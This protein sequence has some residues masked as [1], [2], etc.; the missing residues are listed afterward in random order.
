MRDFENMDSAIAER[1]SAEG[2]LIKEDGHY[3][4]S[5]DYKSSFSEKLKGFNLKHLQ[6][7]A[8]C[9]KANTFINRTTLS[10]I[11]GEEL[12]DRQVRF[13]ITKMEKAG[14]IERKGG[15]KYVQYFQTA[16]FPK[17]N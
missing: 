5:D 2:L 1:L 8:E 16:D 15:G 6:M 10:E 13:L 4:L 12:S 17:F 3:R 14:F 7:V 9:F 11:L